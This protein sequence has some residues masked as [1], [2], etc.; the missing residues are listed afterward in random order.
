MSFPA[1]AMAPESGEMKPIRTG[2]WA[3]AS[4]A[5]PSRRARETVAISMRMVCSFSAPSR[6]KTEQRSHPGRAEH[7][8]HVFVR[9]GALEPAGRVQDLGEQGKVA[10]RVDEDVRQA[11]DPVDGPVDVRLRLE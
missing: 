5:A 6:G 10:G 11:E 9:R 1:C 7:R 3:A 2:P 4:P 8:R